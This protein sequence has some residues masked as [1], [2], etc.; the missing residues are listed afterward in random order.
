MESKGKI[1]KSKNIIHSFKYAFSGL[2]YGFINTKNLHVDFIFMILVIIFGFLFRISYIEWAIVVLCIALVTSL[3][4]MNT[5]IEE[6]VNLA[7]P[8]I[9][10]IA[11]ISKDVAA[12]SVLLSAIFSAIIGIII[13]L[14]KFIDFLGGC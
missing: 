2:K 4:L 14:P 7:S 3:E 11:K 6:A 1:L 9:H 12:A 13:F 5:A 8:D 10:P